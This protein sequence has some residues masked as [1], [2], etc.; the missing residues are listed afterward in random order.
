MRIIFTLV[1]TS[2]LPS[3][4]EPRTTTTR[5]APRRFGNHSHPSWDAGELA[6]LQSSIELSKGLWKALHLGHQTPGID[7]QDSI[8]ARLSSATPSFPSIQTNLAVLER[9]PINHATN[10]PHSTSI[11]PLY[12]IPWTRLEIVRNVT[13]HELPSSPDPPPPSAVPA[14]LPTTTILLQPRVLTT[15]TATTNHHRHSMARRRNAPQLP[16]RLPSQT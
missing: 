5:T 8:H 4:V 16:L 1:A 15:T 11:L 9:Y 10:V 14:A 7:D 2:T 12:V 3:P 13:Q 6:K